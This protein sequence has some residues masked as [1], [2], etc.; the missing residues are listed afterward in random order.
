MTHWRPTEPA[1]I[2]WQCCGN[3]VVMLKG[4]AK[5]GNMERTV[6]FALA[7]DPSLNCQDPGRRVLLKSEYWLIIEELFSA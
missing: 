6:S 1:V 5:Y 7:A 2:Q 4:R 3:A